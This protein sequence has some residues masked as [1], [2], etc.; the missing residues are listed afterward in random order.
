MQR[1][2]N[3]VKQYAWGAASGIPEILGR[4]PDGAP[5]AELWVGAHPGAPSR[6]DGTGLDDLIAQDPVRHLGETSIARFG[7]RLPFLLK[8]LSAGTALSIQSHPSLEQAARGFA[9]EEAAGIPRDAP[10]RSYR[11]EW[12]KPELLHA[13]G[14]FHALC[15]FRP[16]PAVRATLQRFETALADTGAPS[17]QRQ[18]LAAWQAALAQPDEALA[19]RDAVVLV[20]S[21]PG[22][23]GSLADTLAGV[24]ADPASG[25]VDSDHPSH[26]GSSVDPVLTLLETHADFP[27]DAGA[28]VA[29]L[30]RRYVLQEGESLALESGILHAYLCG[31]GVEIMSSS[32]NVLRGGLTHKHTDVPE[33]VRTV[34]F[35]TRAP[36]VLTVD[37][38][39]ELRGTTDDFVLT[40]LSRV[41]DRRLTRPGPL[42]A[43][44]TS[45]SF[46]LDTG[47]QTLT[48][49]RGEAVFVGADEARPAVT[50]EGALFVA[51]TALTA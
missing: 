3:T 13:L 38:S 25:R 16:L 11:D 31:V 21:D 35:D 2:T 5:A 50:G 26:E 29:V 32:D 42:T 36:R 1:L 12:H 46:T 9:A 44:C 19:L 27:G 34:R 15:G 33:L 41:R 28:L 7:A 6:V 24:L 39:A 8:V 37:D 49:R 20:L 22:R 18:S 43:L 23:F 30:L 40:V 45:G 51:S 4:E 47:A 14:E 17:A 10:H 48:L